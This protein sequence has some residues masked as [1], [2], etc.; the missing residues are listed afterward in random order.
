MPIVKKVQARELL[1]SAVVLNLGDVQREA[2]RMVESARAEAESILTAARAEAARLTECAAG[3]GRAE[4][5]AAGEAAGRAEGLAEGTAQGR[6]EAIASMSERLETIATGWNEAL[7]GLV[8]SRDAIREEA[9][10]DLLRLSLAIAERVLGRLP[11]HDPSLVETQ[12]SGAIEMLTGSTS[13]RISLHPED[14]PA[15]ER[16][17]PSVMTRIRGGAEADVSIETDPAIIRGGCMVRAGDGE[18][19][20]RLDVQMSKIVSGLFPELLEA[21]PA[22]SAVPPVVP[23]V[24]EASSESDEDPADGSDAVAD[25]EDDRIDAA[26][27]VPPSPESDLLDDWNVP[28][29]PEDPSD[30]DRGAE[31]SP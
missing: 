22:E 16:H 23:V 1:T 17:L 31:S 20:A 21:P 25:A 9:R 18:I 3:I 29:T 7:D 27:D 26:E 4:G 14:L 24:P 6:E 13:L 2:G 11:A 19:D 28:G 15:I 12:V 5:T 8:A 10:R 30:D